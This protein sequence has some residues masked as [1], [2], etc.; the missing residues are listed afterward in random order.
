MCVNIL[1]KYINIFLE[2]DIK[3]IYSCISCLLVW[4]YGI[5]L[6]TKAHRYLYMIQYTHRVSLNA[7]VQNRPNIF[8]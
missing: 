8:E 3:R 4:K 5:Y 1:P 7:L 6:L 2:D